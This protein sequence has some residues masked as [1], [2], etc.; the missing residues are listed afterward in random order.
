VNVNAERTDFKIHEDNT[1]MIV[2]ELTWNMIRNGIIESS[3]TFLEPYLE[4][5]RRKKN[6]RI[7]QF[8]SNEDQCTDQ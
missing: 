6:E 8:V 1:D 3:K 4:P 2:E 7:E 5:V